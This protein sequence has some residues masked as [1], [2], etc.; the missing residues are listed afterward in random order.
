MRPATP[1]PDDCAVTATGVVTAATG[2]SPYGGGHVRVGR[3]LLCI[4]VGRD[5]A[6]TCAWTARGRHARRATR[7]GP[8]RHPPL[9]LRP[10]GGGPPQRAAGGSAHPLAVDRRA[11]YRSWPRAGDNKANY[12]YTYARLPAREGPSPAG[13]D[14]D[15]RQT[16]PGSSARRNHHQTDVSSIS[17]FQETRF[18]RA[19]PRQHRSLQVASVT[20]STRSGRRGAFPFPGVASSGQVGNSPVASTTTKV[21]STSCLRNCRVSISVSFSVSVASAETEKETSK[22]AAQMGLSGPWCVTGPPAR[23]APQSAHRSS[24]FTYA[25]GPS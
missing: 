20:A 16:E 9:A 18:L 6:P 2:P 22:P 17:A 12:A 7:V 11:R 23:A 19:T 3:A 1:I 15:S 14:D 25:G 8:R 5:R 10:A 24:T 21:R 13:D 4:C